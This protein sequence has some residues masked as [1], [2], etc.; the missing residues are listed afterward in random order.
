MGLEAFRQ[1]DGCPHFWVRVLAVDL[2][3]P[4]DFP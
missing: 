2:R 4:E 1:H 3:V